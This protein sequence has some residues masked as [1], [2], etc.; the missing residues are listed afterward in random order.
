MF[1]NSVSGL[2]L[3]LNIE[4]E[5]YLKYVSDEAGVRVILHDQGMMPFP[6]L[7]GF[8]VSPGTATSVG[9]QK[10]SW[11]LNCRELNEYCSSTSY[12]NPHHTFL[13]LHCRR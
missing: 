11:V 10:V 7:E 4:Q 3:R 5:E 12:L 9:M 6:Y 2:S 1:Y 13:I 8:S